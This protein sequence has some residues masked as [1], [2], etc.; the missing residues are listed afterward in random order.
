MAQVS[1]HDNFFDLGGHSLLT[2][3]MRGEL[4]RVL[5][6]DVAT[7]DLFRYPTISALAAHLAQ[8]REA[9]SATVTQAESRAQ[10]QRNALRQR[11]QVHADQT[12]PVAS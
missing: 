3:K 4:Q 12:R 10:K 2:V 11:R 8:P 9:G 5:R 6:R 7:V 1:V